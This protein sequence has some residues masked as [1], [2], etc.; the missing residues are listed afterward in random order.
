MVSQTQKSKNVK[1][2]R[3]LRTH[4]T[5]KKVLADS[6]RT[7][8]PCWIWPGY[9]AINQEYK[10]IIKIAFFGQILVKLWSWVLKQ[11]GWLEMTSIHLTLVWFGGLFKDPV[12][13]NNENLQAKITE[14][15][16][17][18]RCKWFAS[19]KF[20]P[21]PIICFAL[22]VRQDHDLQRNQRVEVTSPF[23]AQKSSM[24]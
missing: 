19:E 6:A 13:R 8:F 16:K 20:H 18:C 15:P 22:Q 7:I 10:T 4:T 2:T 11:R 14:P 3:S 24:F 9:P 1:I 12:S 21:W 23:I 5:K 17:P